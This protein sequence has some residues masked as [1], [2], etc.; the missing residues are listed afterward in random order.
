MNGYK[1]MKN[2][3]VVPQ[4]VESADD[5]STAKTGRRRTEITIETHEVKTIRIRTIG[6]SG[7]CPTCSGQTTSITPENVAVFMQISVGE[8]LRSIDSGQIHLVGDGNGVQGVC[9][10]SLDHLIGTHD[11]DPQDNFK[12]L[13]FEPDGTIY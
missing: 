9:G 13:L 1:Q 4:I 6:G 2:D 10:N 7:Y 5:G 3:K 11:R 8:V 12:R